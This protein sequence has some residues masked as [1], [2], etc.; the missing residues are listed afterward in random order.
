V[1]QVHREKIERV[2]MHAQKITSKK[3]GTD[4]SGKNYGAFLRSI[5]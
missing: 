2:K 3:S 4:F 5:G 1:K